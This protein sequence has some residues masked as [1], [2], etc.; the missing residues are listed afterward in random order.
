[1]GN[2]SSSPSGRGGPLGPHEFLRRPGHIRSRSGTRASGSRGRDGLVFEEF[3]QA[4]VSMTRKYGGPAWDCP[5]AAAGRPDGRRICLTSE[6]GEGSEFSFSLPLPDR[7]R[8]VRWRRRAC[9]AERARTLVVDDNATN[10][11]VVC[12]MFVSPTCGRRGVRAPAPDSRPSAGRSEARPYSLAIIDAQMPAGTAS[13]WPPTSAPI[14][15]RVHPPADAH[16]RRATRRHPT[17]PD[18][19]DRGLP[20]EAGFPEPTCS[21]PTATL[22]RPV[23]AAGQD[24]V[25]PPPIAESRRR[26]RIL[27]AEDNPVNQEVAATMLRKRGHRWRSSRMAGKRW[28]SRRQPYDAASWISRCPRWMALPP[29]AIRG[30]SARPDFRSSP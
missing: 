5:S 6:V 13:N 19:R 3:T 27:L 30:G 1:M 28:R 17:L 20:H 11:R 9:A 26:L 7:D 18:S 4:D 24:L 10:R 29:P 25:D 14:P 8:S 16:L 2:A 23:P 12:A 21:E 22:L 15:S